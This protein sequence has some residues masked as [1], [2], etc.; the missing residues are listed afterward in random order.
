MVKKPHFCRD[1]EKPFAPSTPPGKNTKKKDGH[2]IFW[3]Y[4]SST[5][6]RRS[7][8]FDVSNESGDDILF[9]QLLVNVTISE[10]KRQMNIQ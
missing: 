6:S 1:R 3:T 10:E 8:L 9:H 2:I 5:L 7:G 4:H